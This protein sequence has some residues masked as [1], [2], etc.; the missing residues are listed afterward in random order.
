[1]IFLF[2]TRWPITKEN[3]AGF[4]YLSKKLAE[5]YPNE[6]RAIELPQRYPISVPKSLLHRIWNRL[7]LKLNYIYLR[8][9]A[10]RFL[11]ENQLGRTDAIISTEYLVK[12][13]HSHYPLIETFKKY[14]S[15]FK[16]AAFVHY[17]PNELGSFSMVELNR[18]MSKVDRI[19]TLGSSLT[20]YLIDEGGSYNQVLTT[21]HYVDDYYYNTEVDL[22]TEF[23]VLVQG[24]HQRD[25]ETLLQIVQS[26]PNVIFK[27]C[28]AGHDLTKEFN[29]PN[30]RLF[31]Y[32]K[33]EE[34]RDLMF[35]TPVSLNV[36]K[37]T[38]GS[39]AIVCSMAAGQAMV[40]TDVGSIRDYCTE[41]NSKFCITVK[42]Y[43]DAL[44]TLGKDINRLQEMRLES[45]RLAQRMKINLFKDDLIAKMAF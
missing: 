32:L 44:N 14:Q 16:L 15:K 34:L 20:R 21:F 13:V 38:I 8:K 17:T 29:F 3:H 4:A 30:V 27:I 5:C 25:N 43:V 37:D 12:G 1:M 23:S 31:G 11:K 42:D 18:W 2:Y 28:T 7:I 45:I 36:M 26:C 19:F 33:E 22:N 10:R 9:F 39:N 41:K 40:V 35:A 24:T 6:F